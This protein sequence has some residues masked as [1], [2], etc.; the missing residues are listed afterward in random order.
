[1]KP[2][3]KTAYVPFTAL[4]LVV[5][6]AAILYIRENRQAPNPS[7]ARDAASSAVAPALP[8]HTAESASAAA[9]HSSS[10]N[11][12]RASSRAQADQFV[13]EAEHCWDDLGCSLE[14]AEHLYVAADDGGSTKVNCLFFYYGRGVPKDVK[15]ARGCF[16]RMGDC[17]PPQSNRSMPP[18]LLSPMYLAAMLLRGQAGL[19][20]PERA[21]QILETC[22]AQGKGV[23]DPGDPAALLNADEKLDQGSELDVCEQ[24]AGT[25]MLTHHCEELWG[26][27][28]AFEGQKAIRVFAGELDS[29]GLNLANRA[30]RAFAGFALDSSLAEG[31]LHELALVESRLVYQAAAYASAQEQR[32]EL[33]KLVTPYAPEANEVTDAEL[34]QAYNRVLKSAID[35]TQRKRL[36]DAQ[37]SWSAY[38]EAEVAFIKHVIG[39]G[40][41][42]KVVEHDVR[43]RLTK[44]RLKELEGFGND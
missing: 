32:T 31:G 39:K 23:V 28:K 7:A 36:G 25:S 16:E 1:M 34:N 8:S 41:D 33:F 9:A 19:R 37:T 13:K 43:A 11:P 30:N 29:A 3:A 4:G 44:Q 22:L 26:E 18:D 5:A 40:Q 38:R 24:V 2:S 42:P 21:K 15:R 17:G 6:A 14:K 12:Y 27:L 20:E 10:P 35:A